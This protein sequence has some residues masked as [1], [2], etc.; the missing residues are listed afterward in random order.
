MVEGSARE[1]EAGSLAAV[2]DVAELDLLLAQ[3][4]PAVI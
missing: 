4:A 3:L 1:L 2:V